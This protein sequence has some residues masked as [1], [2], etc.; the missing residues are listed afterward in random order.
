MRSRLGLALTAALLVSAA[1]RSEGAPISEPGLAGRTDILYFEDFE[2]SSHGG[3]VT[4]DPKLVKFGRRSSKVMYKGGG[5]GVEGKPKNSPRFKKINQVFVRRYIMFA[6]D[7]DFAAGGKIDGSVC[8]APGKR[9]QA[10]FGGKPS[11]GN[12]GFSSRLCWG[13]GGVMTMYTYHADMRGKYGS[14]FRGR[15]RFKPGTWQ[16]VELMIKINTIDEGAT[17]GNHDGEVRLWVDG[18]MDGEKKGLRFRDLPTMAI[19]NWSYGYYFG[20]LWTCPKDQYI[21]M[22]NVVVARS[23]IGPAVFKRPEPKKSSVVVFKPK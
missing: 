16:C 1:V 17:K 12:D 4:E 18:V 10:G 23:Y 6:A 21:Y 8:F 13:R 5:H 19:D 14:D 2:T 9:W 7:F 11:H 22:D 3:V 15:S 20:G